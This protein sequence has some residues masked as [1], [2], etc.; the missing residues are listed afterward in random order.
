VPGAQ[1]ELT[2]RTVESTFATEISEGLVQ[3]VDVIE[4]TSVLAAVGDSMA[5]MPG[6][7]GKFFTALARS[8]VNIRAIA[9]GS[10]ERNISAAI[11]SA[12][13]KRA[14]R[15]VHSAFYLS[16]QTLSIGIIGPGLIGGAFL[17][18]LNRQLEWLRRE[19]KIDLR[20]RAIAN[21]RQMLL[22]D[23][24]IDLSSWKERLA[25]S[26][27]PTD[28]GVFA[29]FVQAPY[30]PHA[31]IIDATSSPDIAQ[32]YPVWLK[33]GIHV[34]TPNKKAN[35]G[36]MA[37]YR[38]LKQTGRASNK[39]YLYETTVGAGLPIIHTLRELVETGDRVLQVEGVLSGTLSYLFNSFTG[40]KPFSAIVTEAMKLGYTEPDPRDDLSG[41]DVARKLV[42]LAREIG[43]SIEVSDIQVR[44]L[45]PE[46]LRQGSIQDFLKN[47]PKF[48][49]EMTAMLEKARA[50]DQVL[51]YV[52][53]ITSEGKGTVDIQAYPRSHAFAG[54]QGSDNIIA[55]TTER[56]KSQPLIV[57]GPGAGPE[58]TA[59]GVFGDLLKLASHLGAPQ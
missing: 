14:L 24:H 28:L 38:E 25:G 48:D 35:T 44:N 57:R 36:S 34:I 29:D 20:V 2:R 18:Q 27:A 46:A 54:L 19:R 53:M 52:G 45:V 47:L 10:S 26:S 15:A 56:Y 5:H 6:I 21:S 59:A 41:M 22:D 31:V 7:A 13:A 1:A 16:N 49:D 42:I 37:F 4:G 9:Q 43:L 55:F 39:Y 30:L 33:K 50:N 58:V 3:K 12:D 17:G 32:R 11:D 23:Q 40:E 8:G 51:R